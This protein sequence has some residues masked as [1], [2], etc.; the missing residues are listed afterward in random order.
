MKLNQSYSIEWV[1]SQ[2][3]NTMYRRG[4]R[5][6]KMKGEITGRKFS[7]TVKIKFSQKWEDEQ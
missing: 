2:L 7:V 6:I 1:I 4:R 3:A 5:E